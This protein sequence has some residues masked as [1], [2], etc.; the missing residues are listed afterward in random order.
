MQTL[1]QASLSGDYQ[2]SLRWLVTNGHTTVGP[3]HTELL[4]RGYMG[5]RIPEHCQVREVSWPAF[6]P[7]EGIREIGRLKRRLA[8]ESDGPLNLREAI[9]CLPAT[10]DTGELFTCALQLAALV[11]D[12][13]AGLVH[14]YRSPAPRPVTSS[15]VGVMP[16]RLGEVLPSNDPAYLLALRGKTLCGNPR[17]GLAERLVGERLQHDGPLSS[18]LMAPVLADGR[19]LAMFELGRTRHPFRVD[20]SDELSEFAACV[21]LRVRG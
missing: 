8:R 14:R 7:L 13:H 3:V 1:T 4:L 15:V 16:E 19:L 2:Q 5:G 11:L 10:R 9:R 21:A 18:V 12:A 6:R 20:D 17:H